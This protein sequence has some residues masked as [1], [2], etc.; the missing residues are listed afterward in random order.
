MKTHLLLLY[1][2]RIYFYICNPILNRKPLSMK[3]FQIL[4][5]AGSLLAHSG[6][7][8]DRDSSNA[9][10]K[11]AKIARL[12]KRISLA[13]NLFNQATEQDPTNTEVYKQF[14]EFAMDIRNYRH[15]YL[16]LTK[17]YELEPQNEAVYKP[18]ANIYFMMGKHKEAIVFSQKWEAIHP[19]DPLHYV[20]GMSNYYTENFHEAINRLLYASEKDPDNATLLYTIGRSY[21]ELSR[22]DQAVLYYKKA[23]DLD[24]KNARYAYELAMVYYSLPNDK[25]SIEMFELA[26]QRGWVQNADYFENLAYCYMNSGNFTKATELLKASL[27][28]RP[29]NLDVTYA[30]AEAYYKGKNYNAA[31]EQWDQ[32]IQMDSKNARS[33]YMIGVSYQKMG[34]KQKGTILC[35]K[36]IG[37]DPSLSALKQKVF[38]GGL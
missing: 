37:M 22:Y 18:L 30:L 4:L 14:S 28:K 12:E 10:L 35:D 13:T 25:K 6:Y 1:L 3:T 11:K 29:Y 2:N 23:V 31:I 7:A 19:E 5:V 36:A 27:E 20:V 8:I 33:L 9:L 34:Q 17:W 32:V 26:A 16:S 38:E 15:A 24:K 21:V